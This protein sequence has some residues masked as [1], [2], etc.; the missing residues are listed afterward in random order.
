MKIVLLGYG[1]MGKLIEKKA[2]GRGHSIHRIIDDATWTPNAIEG[3][4][5]AIEFSNP[6]SA[7]DNILKSFEAKVPIVVG[8]TGWYNDLEEIKNKMNE[9]DGAILPATNFSLGVNIFFEVNRVLAKIM[10][11]KEEYAVGVQEIHHTQKLDSP[12]GTAITTANILL[13]EIDRYDN[14]QESD[15]DKENSI[16]IEALRKPDVPGT[17]T[18]SYVSDVDQLAIKHTAKSRDGFAIGAVIAAEFLKGKTGYFTMKDLIK[19]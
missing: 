2:V 1:K 7:K 19:L 4:D 16:A 17:H 15:S 11:K 12:S 3:A 8:T 9:K 6:E 5:V 13:D 14:W 18:V 10:N